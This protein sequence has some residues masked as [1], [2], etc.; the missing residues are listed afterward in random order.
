MA[1]EMNEIWTVD[2]RI[3]KASAGAIAVRIEAA[4]ANPVNGTAP[5]LR[6]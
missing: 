1:D 4:A 2:R 5:A 3:V 6:G